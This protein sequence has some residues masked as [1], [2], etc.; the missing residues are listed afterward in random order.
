MPRIHFALGSLF[1]LCLFRRSPGKIESSTV[2]LL[3]RSDPKERKLQMSFGDAL[4]RN[5][6]VDRMFAL[7]SEPVVREGWC[8][9]GVWSI[10]FDQLES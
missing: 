3:L 2:Q 7:A 6:T 1:F 9:V 10:V 4:F 5:S 8:H